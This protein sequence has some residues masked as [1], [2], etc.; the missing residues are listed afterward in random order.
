MC[1][2]VAHTKG[3]WA[4]GLTFDRT[5]MGHQYLPTIPPLLPGAGYKQGAG[6]GEYSLDLWGRFWTKLVFCQSPFIHLYEIS[7]GMLFFAA[8]FPDRVWGFTTTRA[9]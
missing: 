5:W 9:A 8:S 7:I 6:S 2:M 4:Q 1:K 3:V